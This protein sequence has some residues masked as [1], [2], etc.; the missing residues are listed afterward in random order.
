MTPGECMTL[1]D[2]SRVNIRLIRPDDTQALIGVFRRLSP[3][4]VY[5]RFFASLPEL[6]ENL[7]WKLSH[8]NYTNRLALVA[9]RDKAETDGDP[10]QMVGVARYDRTDESEPA[11][12]GLAV[13]DEWQG[14]GLGRVLLR[15]LLQAAAQRG[16]T[17]FT[18]DVLS[19]NRR[20]LHL[21]AS[22][23]Q[24]AAMKSSGG[25]T[26][27]ALRLARANESGGVF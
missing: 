26:T 9:E 1:R 4:S 5:Q 11:E 7:A 19:D 23:M 14:R 2:G 8:V 20:M 3:E 25:V 12:I 21:L 22:E 27:L 15:E 17:R 18:A 16:I 10:P 6:P 24:I 13:I